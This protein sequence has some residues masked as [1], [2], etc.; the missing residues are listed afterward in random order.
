MSYVVPELNSW[1]RWLSEKSLRDTLNDGSMAGMLKRFRPLQSELRDYLKTK[2]PNYAVPT[3]F[4]P[5]ERLPLNPNGKVDKPAL[6][7]PDIADIT[8]AKSEDFESRTKTEQL[9]AE[10]W[11]TLLPSCDSASLNLGESF[12]DIG[13][14]SILAQ[15]LL[16]NIKQRFNVQLSM[17]TLF[18][19]S[20]LKSLASAIDRARDP[21]AILAGA[22]GK[23]RQ[24]NGQ[25][26]GDTQRDQDYADD[27]R[28]LV[29]GLAARF[30]SIKQLNFKRPLEIFMTGNVT[31]T[32]SR[33]V[34]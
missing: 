22:D 18:R 8:A 12:F 7:F 26:N 23:Y 28:R 24:A 29:S 10:I 2:L 13:G 17:V 15:R 33:E 6:P 32:E 21:N 9:L 14:H 1:P 31:S 30:P 5:L 27:A 11:G 20:T 16:L 19:D 34:Y 4:I 25:I 3:H